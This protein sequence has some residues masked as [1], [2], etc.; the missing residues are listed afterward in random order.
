MNW[1]TGKSCVGFPV[2]NLISTVGVESV[3]CSK[4]GCI[5]VYV[6]PVH[7]PKILCLAWPVADPLFPLSLYSWPAGARSPLGPVLQTHNIPLS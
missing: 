5:G 6:R 7:D 1:M 3:D 2:C 4:L